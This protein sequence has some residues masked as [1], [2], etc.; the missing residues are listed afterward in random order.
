MNQCTY[1]NRVSAQYLA[2]KCQQFIQKNVLNKNHDFD[3]NNIFLEFFKILFYTQ[4]ILVFKNLSI[5]E[6]SAP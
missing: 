1:R 5:L 4:I 2:G 6:Y 3:K